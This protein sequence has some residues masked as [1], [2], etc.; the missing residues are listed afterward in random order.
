MLYRR[1]RASSRSRRIQSKWRKNHRDFLRIA[2]TSKAPC[3]CSKLR[4]TCIKGI[5]RRISGC[6]RVATNVLVTLAS[7]STRLRH[8]NHT[9]MFWKLNCRIERAHQSVLHDSGYCKRMP[10]QTA[11]IGFNWRRYRAGRQLTR[12][13]FRLRRDLLISRSTFWAS[14]VGCGECHRILP[15]NM[16]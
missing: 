11:E 6:R 7:R 3:G 10:M 9:R 5:A 2:R 13:Q 4:K 12:S 15:L 8:D 16:P 14:L 1:R